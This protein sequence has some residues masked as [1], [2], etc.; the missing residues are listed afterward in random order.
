MTHIQIENIIAN[1]QISEL[2]DIKLLSEKITECSYNPSEFNGLSIKYEK[3]NIAV[4]ILEIGKVVCTGAKE[5]SNAVEKIKKV[6]NQIKKFGLKIKK[7][8]EIT[9]EN[10][11]V[12]TNL[13]KDLNLE[14]IAKN[15][16]FQEVDFH[17][18]TFPGLIYKMDDLQTILIIFNSGKIVCTGAKNIDDATNS[19]NKMEEKLSLIGAL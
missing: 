1:A 13:K 12:T 14:N 5:I 6:A 2:I 3:E 4:I 17:P 7:D 8:Y 19:I 15:L 16:M 10:I 9:I 18:E 11:T